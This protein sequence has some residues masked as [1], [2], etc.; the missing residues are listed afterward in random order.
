MCR[1][2]V[3]CN[4]PLRTVLRGYTGYRKCP[5]RMSCSATCPQTRGPAR[6]RRFRIVFS[7]DRFRSCTRAFGMPRRRT[8]NGDACA[9]RMRELQRCAAVGRRASPSRSNTVRRR[10]TRRALW[11]IGRHAHASSTTAHRRQYPSRDRAIT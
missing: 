8:A 7:R 10:A 5:L 2:P 6:S 1:A 4:D 3:R 11:E 9:V